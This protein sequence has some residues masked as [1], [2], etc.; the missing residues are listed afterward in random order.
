MNGQKDLQA[1]QRLKKRLDVP[2]KK[3]AI[4]QDAVP[5]RLSS[6]KSRIHQPT[7]TRRFDM[8]KLYFQFAVAL[9][10]LLPIV[11]SQRN[12]YYPGGQLSEPDTACQPHAAHSMC[13]NPTDN[14]LSN[15]LCY[16]TAIN[17]LTRGVRL[18]LCTWFK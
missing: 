16:V 13:C 17:R 3:S 2:G 9:C 6:F 8:S 4:L 12:C 1:L 11:S 7:A 15:G 10:A 18:D 5:S 14:C